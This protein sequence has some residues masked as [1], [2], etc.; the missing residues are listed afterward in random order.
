MGV[1]EFSYLSNRRDR[2]YRFSLRIAVVG[3]AADAGDRFGQA[4]LCRE[5]VEPDFGGAGQQVPL[6]ARRHRGWRIGSP[7][8]R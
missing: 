5:P 3:R 6:R 7:P 8:S 2:L 4:D 1:I